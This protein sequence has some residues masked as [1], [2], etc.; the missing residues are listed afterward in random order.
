MQRQIAAF[1][2]KSFS[3]TD[4]QL[5]SENSAETHRALKYKRQYEASWAF[6]NPSL[7]VAASVPQLTEGRAGSAD[8]AAASQHARLEVGGQ[9]ELQLKSRQ[10]GQKKGVSRWKDWQE[11][12]RTT[13]TTKQG[14]HPAHKTQN[15]KIM[16]LSG[17]ET[18]L[19]VLTWTNTSTSSHTQHNPT[20]HTRAQGLK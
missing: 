11:G 3:K 7:M 12:I 6:R 20:A 13:S 15:S 16:L 19:S 10:S 18:S 9:L 2:T 17:H 4:D 1:P 14:M 8:T 5:L